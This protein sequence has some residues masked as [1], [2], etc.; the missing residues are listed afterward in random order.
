GGSPSR[1]SYPTLSWVTSALATSIPPRR[2]AR[3][4]PLLRYRTL[5]VTVGVAREHRDAVE[6]V[7][8][9]RRRELELDRPRRP[10]V[11]YGRLLHKGKRPDE[12]EEE[13]QHRGP[14]AERGD[15]DPAAEELEGVRID[16][17]AARLDEEA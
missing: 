17:H 14:E 1:I 3:G 10:R 16:V 7:H 4:H 2:G 15:R 5:A 13:D 9:H 8:R 11:R 6:V 12:V